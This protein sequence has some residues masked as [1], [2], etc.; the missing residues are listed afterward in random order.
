MIGEDNPVKVEEKVVLQKFDGED[1]LAENEVE[2]L[3]IVD[4][5]VVLHEAIENGEVVGK[6]QQDNL[7]GKYVGTMLIDKEVD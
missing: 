5:T 7:E 3:T 1:A 6:V 2:R 4:G